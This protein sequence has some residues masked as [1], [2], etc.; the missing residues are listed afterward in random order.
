[1]SRESSLVCLVAVFAL[2]LGM[3]GCAGTP[4]NREADSSSPFSSSSP[5]PSPSASPIRITA[6]RLASAYDENSIAANFEYKGKELLVT[7]KVDSNP[8]YGSTSVTLNGNEFMS[9]ISVQCFVDYSQRIKV[10]KLKKGTMA[11][12]QGICDGM[13]VNVELKNCVIK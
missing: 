13:R 9:F 8:N 11:T 12:V 7:G 6:S 4:Q 10:A 3:I 5:S 2:W 1:M